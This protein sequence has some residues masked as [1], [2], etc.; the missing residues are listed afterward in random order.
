LLILSLFINSGGFIII[1]YQV[2]SSVKARMTADI[3][4]GD[5]SI[6]NVVQFRLAKDKLHTDANGFIW[7]EEHEFEYEGALYDIIK[8]KEENENVILF[9]LNDLAES[10]IIKNFSNEINDLARGKI[11]NSKY[12]TSLINLILHALYINPYKLDLQNCRQKYFINTTLY[13]PAC[14]IGIL[15]PP[16]KLS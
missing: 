13:I 3:R 8:V 6:E 1:F 7:K 9:C 16:P 11:N 5:Y 2:H 10:Q 12:K 4:K 14:F 15:S